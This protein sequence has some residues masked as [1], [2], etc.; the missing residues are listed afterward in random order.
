ME[1]IL[2]KLSLITYKYFKLTLFSIKSEITKNG[3]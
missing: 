3:L 1:K 2:S